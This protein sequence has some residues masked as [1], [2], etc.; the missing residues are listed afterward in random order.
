M[1]GFPEG[2]EVVRTY[3]EEDVQDMEGLG[4][5]ERG[6]KKTGQWAFLFGRGREGEVLVRDIGA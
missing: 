2:K 6:L 1:S 3:S 4:Q 5:G